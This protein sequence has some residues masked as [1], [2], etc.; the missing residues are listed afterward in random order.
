MWQDYVLAVGA[1]LLAAA[2]VPSI[3]S[4]S[5][6]A[7]STSLLTGSVLVLFTVTFVSLQLWIS[8]FAELLSVIMWAIL[9]VQVIRRKPHQS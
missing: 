6:P 7:L 3:R 2:L 5:K 1:F 4:Q 8:A 9:A